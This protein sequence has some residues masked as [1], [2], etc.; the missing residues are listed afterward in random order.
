[1]K[2]Y[3]HKPEATAEMFVDG[4]DGRWMKTG[5]IAYVDSQRRFFIVDRMK[6]LIKVKGNQVAP[7]ELE[8]VLLEHP[9]IQDAC[10]V[11]VT[12]S[13]EELPR[14]YVV[15]SEGANVVGEEVAEWISKRVSKHKRLAAG[16]VIVDAVPK[17][18]VSQVNDHEKW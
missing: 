12:I 1:M 10:V 3:W 7:A 18:P 5:D 16:V 2:G 9:Q 8:G 4:P 13:G 15:L 11:G 14:A 17:N 6:E